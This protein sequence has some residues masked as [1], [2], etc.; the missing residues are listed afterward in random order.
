[1]PKLRSNISKAVVPSKHTA[2]SAVILISV[3]YVPGIPF[4]C[5]ANSI[6]AALWVVIPP[7]FFFWSL[8]Y[9]WWSW[10]G[11]LLINE[12]CPPLSEVQNPGWSHLFSLELD[13]CVKTQGL[14]SLSISA[15]WI[16]RAA[17]MIALSE[18]GL[19]GCWLDSL[20]C[21]RSFQY[22]IFLPVLTKGWVWSF[23][24]KGHQ[25]QL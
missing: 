21:P 14:T 19:F 25:G 6:L 13:V 15:A 2:G 7:L 23:S 22:I 18:A 24:I 5:F 4:P 8:H 12:L 1:M 10:W 16:P 9:S 11:L 17:L 3:F 20:K